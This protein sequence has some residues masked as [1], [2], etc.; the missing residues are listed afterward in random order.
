MIGLL[1]SEIIIMSENKRPLFIVTSALR[2]NIGV[3]NDDERFKQTMKTL[4]S[5][6]SKCPNAYIIFAD[7]ST[8]EVPAMEF[9]AISKNVN[10]F[11]KMHEKY[12]EDVIYFSQSG[13]KSHAET[14]LLFHVFLRIK[15]DP[16]L[17]MILPSVSRIF[18]ITGRLELDDGFDIK[19][20]DNLEGKYV[21]KKRVPTWMP[22]P[23]VASHVFDTRLYSV[24]PSNLL[25]YMEIL[26]K[27]FQMLDFVDTEHAHFANIP[28]DK[29]VEFDKVHCKGQVASTGEWKYD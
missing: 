8:R 3:F 24:C 25:E 28:Q 29:L 11:M 26:Q 9:L 20:Y 7:A 12:N 13:M 10:Y 19:A 5:I 23:H 15:V 17:Q 4:N 16:N 14:C 6:R 21:F 1:Y 27:N 22:E 18:K 2:P